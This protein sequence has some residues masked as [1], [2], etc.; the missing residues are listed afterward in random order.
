[1]PPGSVPNNNGQIS[2]QIESPLPNSNNNNNTNEPVIKIE[3]TSSSSLLETSTPPPPSLASNAS[4][5]PSQLQLTT[6]LSNGNGFIPQLAF[7]NLYIQS[8]IDSATF[9][10]V[11]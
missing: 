6:Q 10:C 2:P 8:K 4:N 1:M 5:G 3:S 9:L 11:F 7:G